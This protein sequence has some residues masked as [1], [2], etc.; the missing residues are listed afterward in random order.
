MKLKL[1]FMVM[2]PNFK[3]STEEARGVLP[4]SVDYESI[5]YNLSRVI[6]LPKAL[7]EGNLELL[8]DVLSDKLHEPYRIPLIKDADLL[9]KVAHDNG[10]AACVSGSGS[11]LLFIGYDYN[12]LDLIKNL[13]LK[14]EWNLL[15][16]EINR[17]KTKVVKRG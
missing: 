1:K 7:M 8:R 9:L 11:T 14:E 10:Y 13:S 16:C 17:E 4:K 6:H 5:V 2:Y 12:L 15:M 3:V